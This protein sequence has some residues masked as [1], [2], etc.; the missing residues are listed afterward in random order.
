MARLIASLIVD[1]EFEAHVH[2]EKYF[3]KR[4]DFSHVDQ[5]SENSIGA[6]GDEDLFCALPQRIFHDRWRQVTHQP[7]QHHWRK[8]L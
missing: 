8:Q 4:S 6:V 2:K 1:R 5:A 7:R 3:L